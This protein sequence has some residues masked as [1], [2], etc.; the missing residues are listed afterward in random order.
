MTFRNGKENFSLAG[1]LTIP[2]GE[3][4]F[5]AVVLVS[6]SGQQNRDEELM[7]HRPFW[8]IADYLSRNGVAVLRYD[9]RGEGQSEGDPKMATT[10]DLSYDAEAAFD[11][12]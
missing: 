5:P 3:G 12:L 1:T 4:P 10:M 11:F 9:D 6:G 2:E 8:V 7:N